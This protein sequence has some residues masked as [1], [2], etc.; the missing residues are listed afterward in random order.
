MVCSK[1]YIRGINSLTIVSRSKPNC[2]DMPIMLRFYLEFVLHNKLFVEKDVNRRYERA[3]VVAKRAEEDLVATFTMTD[4]LQD[5]WG[6]ACKSFWG[7][8]HRTPAWEDAKPP[9]SQGHSEV[10][11]EVNQP[12]LVTVNY[13]F[14]KKSVKEEA[15]RTP[16]LLEKTIREEATFE[17]VDGGPPT[18][19]MVEEC[20]HPMTNGD[21]VENEDAQQ[22]VDDLWG[23]YSHRPPSKDLASEW[24]LPKEEEEDPWGPFVEPTLFEFIG[25]SEFPTRRIPIRVEMSTRVL[26]GI[27]PP[28]PASTSIVASRL[29]TLVLQPWPNP[30]NDDDS[31]VK[32]P[33]MLDFW[34]GDQEK[35]DLRAASLKLARGFDPTEDEIRVFVEPKAADKC[36]LGMGII[37]TWVQVGRRADLE[38][39]SKP[40]KRKKHS[41]DDWW[42][43]ERLEHVIPSYWTPNDPHRDMT[44]IENNPVYAYDN[45]DDGI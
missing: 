41:G 13:E 45:D 17:E 10:S 4:A 31:L 38:P 29:A 39:T 16:P 1:F 24:S 3:L 20:A 30:S 14:G 37:A 5:P 22:K 40:T 35:R 12:K 18:A 36:R 33:Q 11:D 15:A 21:I 26:V 32:P 34:K 23:P 43:I 6:L 27:L 7:Q 8:L 42:Y 28:D 9:S 2:R 19:A 44:R 25:P